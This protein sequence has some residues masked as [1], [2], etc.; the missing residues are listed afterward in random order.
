VIGATTATTTFINAELWGSDARSLRIEAT[1]ISALGARPA[2]GERVL[3]L[4][5]DRIFPGLINAHDHLQLNGLPHLIYRPRYANASRWISDVKRRLD[6]DPELIAQRAVSRAD[7]LLL[8][9]IKNILSGVTTVAHHDPLHACLIG[10]QFPT[11]VLSQFGW[12]HSLYLDGAAS[13]RRSH[14]ATPVGQP[15]IIHAGEGTDAEAAAE[16]DRLLDL[17]CITSNTLL[18]HGIAFSA[19]QQRLLATAG[20]GLIWCPSSNLNLYGST[21]DVSEL[22][23]LRRIALGSDSRISGGRDLLEELRLAREV[24]GH[25]EDTVVPLVT[26]QA[27]TLLRFADRGVL[28]QGALADLMVLPAGMSLSQATRA[29]IRLVVLDGRP[30]YGDWCYAAALDS[31]ENFA[32]V[33]IDGREKALARAWVQRLAQSPLREPGLEWAAQLR[34][35][36]QQRH[37]HPGGI[38]A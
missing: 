25:D 34:G 15:W 13:V 23:A 12:S 22:I 17:D 11:R 37:H 20:A 38:P 18:V 24:S 29:D 33:R 31:P 27:A 8:G 36:P 19:H 10:S 30:C 9:G 5:G 4:G 21:P 16:F 6:S 26:G 7:R 3:D 35:T 28:R 32:R 14:H 2:S 1:R